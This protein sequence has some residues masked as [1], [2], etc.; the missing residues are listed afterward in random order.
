MKRKLVWLGFR[1]FF[2]YY[3]RLQYPGL[4]KQVLPY[5]QE[6]GEERT[7]A[8]GGHTHCKGMP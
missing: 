2:P 4:G 5:N 8:A 3:A 6:P 1:V 7:R